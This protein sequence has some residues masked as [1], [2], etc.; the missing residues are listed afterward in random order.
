[1][2]SA[3]QCS[4]KI[5][6]KTI[7]ILKNT[8]IFSSI[9]FPPSICRLLE[10]FLEKTQNQFEN[11]IISFEE[12]IFVISEHYLELSKNY[13]EVILRFKRHWDGDMEIITQ[14]EE[15]LQTLL[16]LFEKI[17]KEKEESCLEKL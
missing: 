5:D 8:L 10:R 6:L 11:S 14:T 4:K 13:K 15:G 7:S 1:M 17:I 12:Y 3:D 2:I 9:V 16:N